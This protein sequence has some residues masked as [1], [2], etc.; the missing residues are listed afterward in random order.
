[1][2]VVVVGGVAAELG[3]WAALVLVLS[4]GVEKQQACA[5]LYALRFRTR[6]V[7]P[8]HS[9]KYVVVATS[10]IDSSPSH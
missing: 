2:V 4:V 9:R 8:G 3:A 6:F 1:M 10:P 5:G 7:V